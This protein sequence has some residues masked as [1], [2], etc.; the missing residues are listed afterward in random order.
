K[1][2]EERLSGE[3]LKPDRRRIRQID[4]Q[5]V[6]ITKRPALERLRRES[7]LEFE[8]GKGVRAERNSPPRIVVRGVALEH[9][10]FVLSR[11]FG[12]ENGERQPSRTRAYDQDLHRR[13]PVVLNN[14]KLE[15]RNL[16]P[17][18]T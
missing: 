5:L 8:K 17:I 1:G 11:G 14:R 2:R 4:H 10:D 15:C 9:G 12:H 16:R 18:G 6:A 3:R 13:A 7:F